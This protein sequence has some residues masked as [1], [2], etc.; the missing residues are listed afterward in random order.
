MTCV[1]CLG[2]IPSQSSKNI[3]ESFFS[4]LFVCRNVDELLKV[5]FLNVKMRLHL[6]TFFV[7]CFVTSIENKKKMK[8][9]LLKHLISL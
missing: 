9:N 4:R 8:C 1:I 5:S 2:I 6:L 7:I 3:F